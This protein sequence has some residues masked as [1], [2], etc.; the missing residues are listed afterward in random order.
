MHL[1]QLSTTQYTTIKREMC[2]LYRNVAWGMRSAEME[3]ACI[4]ALPASMVLACI[5]WTPAV[6]GSLVMPCISAVR[7]CGIT[8]HVRGMHWG[9]VPSG[10]V[11]VAGAAV[12]VRAPVASG[13]V[14]EWRGMGSG[15]VSVPGRSATARVPLRGFPPARTGPLSP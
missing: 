4:A 11:T 8:I 6:F 1:Y 12:S 7:F 3:C 15:T 10:P 2:S 9:S 5:P 13:G 14:L